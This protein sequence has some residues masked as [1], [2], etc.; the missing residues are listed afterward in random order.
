MNRCR[1]FVGLAVAC[2]VA[3]GVGV[4]QTPDE[5]KPKVPLVS[6]VGCANRM[7]DGT[8]M[9]INS[10]EG[11]ETERLYSSEKEIEE[12]R[13]TK[14]GDHRY[15][16]IGIAEFLTKEELLRHLQREEFTRPEVAN[17]TGQLQHGQKLVVKGL[18]ITASNE[19]RLNLV[20]VQQLGYTCE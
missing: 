10:T 18:L 14:F 6:V 19:R 1:A 2:G 15:K 5:S 16:L 12:A 4:A 17:A 20:S 9:L 8:W 7:P 13:K 3:A 11:I